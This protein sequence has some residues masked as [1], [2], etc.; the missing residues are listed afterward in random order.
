MSAKETDE[1]A[2]ETAEAERLRARI[3]QLEDELASLQAWANGVVAEAQKRVYWLDRLHLDLDPIMRR[4]PVDFGVDVY[5]RLMH[6]WYLW[7]LRPADAV[8]RFIRW[9]S[10]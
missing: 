5:R 8:R 9:L 6:W 4:V 7:G 1:L 10:P 3:A 2:A